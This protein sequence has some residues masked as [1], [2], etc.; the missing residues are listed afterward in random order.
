MRVLI[1]VALSICSLV[2][3]AEQS[4]GN[5]Y[6]AT[7][8]VTASRAEEPL[9]DTPAR[10]Q[11]LDAATI[12]SLN[13]RDAREALR[14]VPGLQ[15]RPIHGKHGTEVFLQ[16]MDGNRVLVLVDG[17]PI[18]PTTGSTA[19]VTQLATLDIQ[20]IEILPGAASSLYGSA[21]MGGVVNIITRPL[22]AEP[23]IILSM[24]AG[25]YPGKEVHDDPLPQR[26]YQAVASTG[27]GSS[28]LEDHRLQVS[29][30]HRESS[31]F[32]LN[33]DSYPTSHFD[34][35]RSNIVLR[36]D[37]DWD[38][39]LGEGGS[40][41]LVEHFQE[42]L[43][44]RQYTL[45]GNEGRKEEELTRW[46]FVGGGDQVIDFGLLSWV[47]MW[48]R[49]TDHTAQLDN[50]SDQMAGNIWRNPHYQQGKVGLQWN[51]FERLSDLLD[52]ELVAGA[53]LFREEVDQSKREISLSI[54]D[55]LSPDA[56]VHELDNG[57]YDI[58]LPEV[59]EKG[60]QAVDVFTQA[61]LDLYASDSF[62]LDLSPGVRWQ[63]DSNFGNFTAPSVG[64]RQ[65]F[66]LVNDWS[67]QTR[68]S[69]GVGY[70]VPNLK[71]RHFV[72]DHSVH[73]YKVL[74]NPDLEPEHSRSIQTSFVLSDQQALQ[75]EV[76]FFNSRI[77]DLIETVD[78][79]E[80][81]NMGR[82]SIYRYDNY[83][84]TLTRG[85]DLSVRTHVWDWLQQR[86][87]FSYLDARDL[88]KNAPLPNRAKHHIKGYWRTIF[89]DRFSA[90][91]TAEMQGP[92]FTKINTSVA[93]SETSPAYWRWD[94]ATNLELT[95]RLRWY[96][97]MKNI[98]DSVRNP[99]DS[100]D[101][102]LSEGR[103]LYTGFELTL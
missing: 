75:F 27:L 95:P 33:R 81:E 26:H 73:G 30:D 74:G 35:H 7:I 60:R 9:A 24:D 15:L 20:Q 87:S 78:T 10:M 44:N 4:T 61:T 92:I 98:T 77:F 97:G 14:V 39:R 99:R 102:R 46:R 66:A 45:A 62:E 38:N 57:T 28:A 19:D 1:P 85:Y 54:P 43:T 36:L 16:G 86:L 40:R 3:H 53:E 103:Y 65:S 93:D 32:D 70:R 64:L 79:G 49:Q 11:V 88:D 2:S 71:E 25:T 72:F 82:V 94:L 67:L 89:T 63:N 6:L 41:L 91:V 96:S 84:N 80:R 34:G 18:S 83:A 50:S 101:R 52:I 76:A 21:A 69:I 23:K 59:P 29:I 58:T 68:Q 90:T 51:W 8:V 55:E 13:P 12:E 42:K 31:D 37:S 47:A 17:L 22:D 5:N 100:Y 48:E 56:S